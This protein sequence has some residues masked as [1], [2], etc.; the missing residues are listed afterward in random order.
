MIDLPAPAGL[1]PEC[2]SSTKFPFQ[3]A[4]R[5][6]NDIPVERVIKNM[7]GCPPHNK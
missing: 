7:H 6:E 4:Q 1:A 2:S 3:L 5:V